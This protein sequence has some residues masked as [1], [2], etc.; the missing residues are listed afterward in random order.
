MFLKKIINSIADAGKELLNKALPVQKN[1]ETLLELCDD[2]I[3][4]KGVASGIAI[5]RE[6]SEIYLSLSKED[7][8]KFFIA[9][10]EKFKP[11]L[12]AAEKKSLEFIK[13]KNTNTL[14]ELSS[15]AEGNR[16]EFIRRMN[17]APNG[18]AFLVSMRE[19]LLR[20]V[21]EDS[22]LSNLDED[23]RHLFRSW[24]NPGFLRLE[25]I[26]WDTKAA[27]LER[28][29]SY[30]K[31]HKIKDMTDLKRRLDEDRRFY[32]YF[33]P[34]LPD[35]PLIFVQ[36]A[37]TQGLAS[38]VQDIIKPM[39][40]NQPKADTATFYSI[41]NC[42]QGL[43]SVTL[44]NFLIKRVVYEIQQENPKIKHFGTLSPL[45]GFAEWVNYIEENKLRSILGSEDYE[46][47]KF[48]RSTDIKI[49]DPR[50]IEHKKI[51]KKLTI[52]YLIKE[53][54]NDKPVN[55]V[56]RFHLG[57]G[58]SI[59]NIVINGNISDYGYNESFGIMVNYIYHL[60]K[61][62]KI[63]EEYISNHQIS[64]SDKIKKYV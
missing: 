25:R 23:F 12:E 36:V 63:H 21:L 26:T 13:N 59:E 15:L 29:I 27:V 55:P 48:L 18:T 11:N 39:T 9:V 3:S 33:H 49:G 46:K 20:F 34:V 50:I 14:K 1:L 38:S 6:I 42:Q 43:T 22:S 16:Q 44:G 7:K 28:I 4:Y 31:V 54:V 47:V 17:M 24:F 19:D 61:L 62:E 60:D 2:L 32:A 53:K 52:H 51:I 35:E 30:E 64:Y 8:K 5:A 57:N 37:F 56:T 58:A 41:S 40:P 45:P 10:D